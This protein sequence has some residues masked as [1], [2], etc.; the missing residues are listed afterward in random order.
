M[1]NYSAFRIYPTATLTAKIKAVR[2]R[3]NHALGSYRHFPAARIGKG[4]KLI[5]TKTAE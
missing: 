4:A 2:V 1:A 3:M 5:Q